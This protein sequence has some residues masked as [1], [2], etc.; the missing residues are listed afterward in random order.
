MM[1]F[2]SKQS[3]VHGEEERGLGVNMD[4]SGVGMLEAG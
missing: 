1:R 4:S 2:E 3:T